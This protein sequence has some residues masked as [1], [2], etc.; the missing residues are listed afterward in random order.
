M[1]FKIEDKTEE[2]FFSSIEGHWK[3]LLNELGYDELKSAVEKQGLELVKLQGGSSAN[4]IG[5]KAQIEAKLKQNETKI[6]QAL[7]VKGSDHSL[8]S[9]KADTLTS[10]ITDS[11]LNYRVP[12]VGQLSYQQPTVASLFTSVTLPSNSGGSLAYLDWD[13]AS[14]VR[15]AAMRAEG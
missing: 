6:K 13:S 8:F 5:L 12:E 9:I 1:S 15:A 2:E 7:S 4:N 3:G 10:S 11:T 14:S